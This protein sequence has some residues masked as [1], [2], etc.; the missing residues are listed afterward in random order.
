MKKKSSYKSGINLD[1]FVGLVGDF[2]LDDERHLLVVH[3][4][5]LNVLVGELDH[6]GLELALARTRRQPEARRAHDHNHVAVLARVAGTMREHEVAVA[7]ELVHVL[8]VV[9]VA[10]V[11]FEKVQVNVVVLRYFDLLSL[12]ILH[13][14]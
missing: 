1:D 7:L 11:L 12:K 8:Q 2:D 4:H 5:A 10:V 14:L 6:L 13:R 9:Q 3:A